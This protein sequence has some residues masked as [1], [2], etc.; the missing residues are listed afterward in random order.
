MRHGSDYDQKNMAEK[1]PAHLLAQINAK[2]KDDPNQ[3]FLRSIRRT[4]EQKVEK[5]AQD[6]GIEAE[7]DVI[8]LTAEHQMEEAG[9]DW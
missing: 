9:I 8:R 3:T 7:E 5:V 1:L 6:E 4:Y 2:L